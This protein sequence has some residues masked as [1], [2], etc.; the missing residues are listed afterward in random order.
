MKLTIMKPTMP[1]SVTQGLAHWSRSLILFVSCI[2]LIVSCAAPTVSLRMG[3]SAWPGWLPWQVAAEAKL[4]PE[5]VT[6]QWFDGYVD[7]ILALARN[8]SEFNSQTLT[9]TLSAIA[10]GADQVIVLTNDNSTGNDQIIV[11]PT[12]K[13]IKDLKGKFV[14]VEK[15]SVDHFLLGQGLEKAGMTLEE[16]KLVTLETGEASRRF[17]DGSFD[18]VATFAP[19]TTD[20]MKRSGSRVLFSSADFPGT[21]S[22]HLVASRETIEKHPEQVQALVNAWFD[23]LKLIEAK[24]TQALETMAKLAKVTVP[25][26]QS[27]EQGT[28][29][30]SLKDNLSAFET[31]SEMTSLPFAA[32]QNLEF[33]K[34]TGFVHKDIDIAKLFDDRFVKAAATRG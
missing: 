24:P 31:R 5:S 16:V 27:Y 33:L 12:I 9:D 29:I 25:E 19:F 10:S 11:S 15:G 2:A 32:Q 7:S 21:I 22:D 26:Y 1:R 20:A 6:L 13:T 18:A 28:Q 8:K 14:A 30:F 4:L 3:F 17:G 34:R 23:T